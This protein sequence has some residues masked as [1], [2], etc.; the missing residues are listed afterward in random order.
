MFSLSLAQRLDRLT[1]IEARMVGQ[2]QPLEGSSSRKGR[3]HGNKGT[4]VA[5]REMAV[6]GYGDAALPMAWGA[7]VIC[8]VWSVW[9]PRP[10]PRGD[11]PGGGEYPIGKLCGLLTLVMQMAS[12]TASF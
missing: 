9:V 11:G 7:A 5:S 3:G 1:E 10:L 12:S 8:G 4:G 6:K 2:T